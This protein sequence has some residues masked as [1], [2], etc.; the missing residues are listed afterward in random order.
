MCNF[1]LVLSAP[2]FSCP[3]SQKAGN[4]FLNF[5]EMS[6]IQHKFAV[7]CKD[8]GLTFNTELLCEA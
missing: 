5:T 8:Q 2:V 6:D 4:N 3:Y 7:S 1:L